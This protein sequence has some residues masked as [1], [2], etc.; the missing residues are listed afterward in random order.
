MDASRRAMVLHV[1]QEGNLLRMCA[2]P[3][4]DVAD[5]I[6]S[7]VEVAVSA[8]LGE[9]RGEGS[10]N[11][12]DTFSLDAVKLSERTLVGDMFRS[13]LYAL[14]QYHANGAIDNEVLTELYRELVHETFELL[15]MQSTA[16]TDRR[17]DG[18]LE[19][20]LN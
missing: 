13:G 15:K 12:K 17:N 8:K 10:T 2:E 16:G 9:Q 11:V 7:A 5:K 18:V 4:P 1:D 14:C 3:P 6:T 19:V 20:P